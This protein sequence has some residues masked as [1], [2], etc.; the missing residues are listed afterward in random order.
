MRSFLGIVHSLLAFA[1]VAMASSPVSAVTV[2]VT[3]ENLAPENSIAT[4]PVR[5]GFG[6]GTF[7]AFDEGAAAFLLGNPTIADAP[8]VT[9]AEGGS[10]SNWFPAF[11]AAEPNANLGSVVGGSGAAVPPFTPG[12]SNFTDIEV[13]PS[14]QY[15]TFGTMVVPST[16]FFLGNDSPTQYQV[17]D[18]GGALTLGSIL[19]TASDIWD[20]GSETENPLNAAF[21]QVGT[22]ALREDENGTVE[23]NFSEL[24]AYDG[25]VTGEGY[26]F[27]SSLLSADT[28]V[29]S[30]SFSIVPE[31]SA[32]VLALGS[33]AGACVVRRRHAS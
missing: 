27:D 23:F 5:F 24:S 18:A 33:V 6:N 15:F 4:A 17:F 7:D 8:I 1:L 9:I 25:L 10:G 2:R 22:N 3:V 14:N 19:L 32:I 28:P 21:L 13:D 12:E 11:E 31:P 16:D 26:T 29:L 20:A 30:I